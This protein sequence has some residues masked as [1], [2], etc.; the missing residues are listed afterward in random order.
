MPIIGVTGSFG[1][2]KTTV[3]RVFKKLGAH[4][5]DADEIA[6]SLLKNNKKIIKKIVSEYGQE[7]L[8]RN[9]EIDRRRLSV[10]VFNDRDRLSVLNNIIHPEAI[11]IIKS[12][13]KRYLRRPIVI[14][15]P[16]LIEVGLARLVDYL[17]VVKLNQG[18]QINR[19]QKKYKISKKAILK[20]VK[21]QLPL[22]LK[23]R[24]ADFVINNNGSKAE[25]EREVKKIW[26]QI[27][28]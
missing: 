5:I 10:L 8:N 2:G 16:L 22:R 4:V 17:V 27:T 11:A 7:I 9:K 26:R 12:Q 15:A 19:L 13:I 25:T 18:E 3:A 28:R 24:Q 14:D 23:I 20:R 21:M 6:H 1:T